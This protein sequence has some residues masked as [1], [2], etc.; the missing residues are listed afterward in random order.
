VP[1]SVTVPQGATS[2]TFPITTN[3]VS[4]STSLTISG[5]DNTTQTA[6]LT[7]TPPVLLSIL[8]NA[9]SV[10]G[11]TSSTGTVTLASPAPS[12]GALVTLTNDVPVA[13]PHTI[14][15]VTY[16]GALQANGSISPAGLQADGA[17]Y[18]STL[19]PSYYTNP[20]SGTVLAVS[21]LPGLTVTLTNSAQLP[22]QYDT[23]CPAFDC[24]WLGNFN[25]GADILWDGG[26]YVNGNWVG[27]GPLTVTFSSPQR[28]LG[29]QIMPDE[30][31][32]FTASLCA[33]DSSNTPLGCSSFSGLG[34]A[35][36]QAIPVGL[37]DDTQE[38]SKV[39]IDGG[40]ALYAHDFAI[41]DMF[42]T[43]AARPVVATV[44]GSVTVPAGQTT[45]TFTVTTSAVNTST[46]VNITG[47]YSGTQTTGTV[48]VTSIIP[49]I[50]TVSLSPNT[51]TGGSSTTGTVTLSSP[52]V[53]GG[54]MV[55]LSSD[56]AAASV[57]ASITVPAHATTATFPVNTTAVISTTTPNITASFNSTQG[58]AQL[59]VNPPPPP[60]VSQLILGASTGLSN[61]LAVVLPS[62]LSVLVS[63]ASVE[64]GTA[65]ATGTVT[66]KAAAPAGGITVA[67][68]ATSQAGSVP[69]SVKV[70]AGATT[71]KFTALTKTVP[72][73]T[74]DT[75]TATLNG[76]AN[77]TLTINPPAISSVTLAPAS[78]IGGATSTATVKLNQTAPTGGVV[79]SVASGS[80]A[81]ATLS[82]SSV[83]V[84][85]GSSST[86]FTVT[87]IP[88]GAKATSSITA[89]LAGGGTKSATLTINPPTLS[90]L[91][92]SP[93]TVTH[94]ALSTGTVTISGAAPAG[95]FVVT[96]SS[97]SPSVATVPPTTTVPAGATT[98]KFTVTSVLP[99]TSTIS[100]SQT[101]STTRKAGLKVN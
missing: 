10:P 13:Q 57:P 94:P 88:V 11:G 72:V 49:G 18:W 23:E 47:T 43:N 58:T 54:A 64:G 2:A 39:I 87:S 20:P 77:A 14:Q 53:V 95:G 29:F 51:V 44:P 81:V 66:L 12:G 65:N 63:P 45:G 33:Y 34:S 16:P 48:Q 67:L 101:G 100:A 91:T 31:G 69:A 59:T 9:N 75:I 28:G 40:G 61:K 68:S 83:T 97:S 99:G 30:L 84:P 78:L 56:N 55:M 36:D 52:A 3:Q 37:Y 96:L 27:N 32:A 21:G 50:S 90:S 19:G 6:T 74:L 89:T 82:V 41:G 5:N 86:T 70:A 25:P 92:L 80:T 93:A 73:V 85:A 60:G 62:I 26:T 4:T 38:I 42:I 35:N 22:L 24:A 7:L 76:S 17:I 46:F 1:A 71:A 79:V 15:A 98:V 8:M